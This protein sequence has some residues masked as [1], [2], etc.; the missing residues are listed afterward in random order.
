MHGRFQFAVASAIACVVLV[1]LVSPA[2]PSPPAKEPSSH[3]VQRPN[4]S[5]HITAIPSTTGVFDPGVVHEMVL[6]RSGHPTA[7][8]CDIVDVTT[9]RLC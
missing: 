7:S 2:V 4:V 8:G 3:T 1:T 5:V 9:A 6:M